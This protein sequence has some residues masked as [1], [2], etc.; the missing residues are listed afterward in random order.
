MNV[1]E[2]YLLKFID[3]ENKAFRIVF[4]TKEIKDKIIYLNTIEQLFNKG[5]D[6]ENLEL[7][8]F[9]AES[10]ILYKKQ[11]GQKF[12]NVTLNDTGVFYDSFTVTVGKDFFLID[13]DPQKEETN[14]LDVYGEDVIGLTNESKNEL[15]IL[16]YKILGEKIRSLK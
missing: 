1:L 2:K 9:Y 5:V 16:A 11:R 4:D 10:T 3:L 6:S 13:A 8:P 12:E 15:M 14:L 7:F